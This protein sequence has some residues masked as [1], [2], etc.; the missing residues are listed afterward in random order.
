MRSD[1]KYSIRERLILETAL[2]VMLAGDFESASIRQVSKQSMLSEEL[3]I[4]IFKTDD[5]LR[6]A[7]MEYAAIQWVRYVKKDIQYE[8]D[9]RCKLKK[10][11]RHYFAGTESHPDSLSLY[12]DIWKRIRDSSKGNEDDLKEELGKI[13]DLYA[14]VFE[15][16]L[17]T[18]FPLRA[19]LGSQRR[20]LAWIMVVIS[21]GLHIQSLI[22]P[23]SLDYDGIGEMINNMVEG[24]L[25]RNEEL[26]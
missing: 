23:D 18:E 9:R 20:Q 10:I 6:M 7:A 3:I 15:E 24:L 11:V 22:R 8:I 16:L 1:R 12:I 13:Y 2:K 25:K 21:D 19:E 26:L 17:L 5:R 4:S 14:E